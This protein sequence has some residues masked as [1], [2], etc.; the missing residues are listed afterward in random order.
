MKNDFN[1]SILLQQICNSV[2][3]ISQFFDHEVFRHILELVIDH[4]EEVT[5]VIF[6]NMHEKNS[7]IIDHSKAIS[8]GDHLTELVAKLESKNREVDRRI[9]YQTN[10]AKNYETFLSKKEVMYSLF[11]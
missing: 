5:R 2:T 10:R 9:A 6:K 7:I 3:E 11:Y 1:F 4:R 8:G